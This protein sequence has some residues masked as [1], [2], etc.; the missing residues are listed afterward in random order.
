MQAR[1]LHPRRLPEGRRRARPPRRGPS[2]AAG[3]VDGHYEEAVDKPRA[4][5]T[6][7]ST[8]PATS[9]P[10]PDRRYTSERRLPVTG[11]RDDR[12]RPGRGADRGRQPGQ[13][14]PGGAAHPARPVALGHRVR[15]PVPRVVHRLP[16]ERPWS[17]QPARGRST[18][19]CAPSNCWPCSMPAWSVF[20]LGPDPEVT[21]HD[22]RPRG[23]SLHPARSAVDGHGQRG[24]AG[25]SRSPVA[26]PVRA[27]PCSAG[28]TPRVA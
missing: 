18:T 25:S 21:R 26:G 11:L 22:G 15:R 24:R 14:G 19:T 7:A 3:W 12:N 2:C 6:A 13:G 8:R 27:R 17:D 4:A 16:V 28:S 23:T 9:S 10:A 5:R 20:P 1:Y